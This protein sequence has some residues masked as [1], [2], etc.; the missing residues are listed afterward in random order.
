M[1][2]RAG[3]IGLYDV[4]MIKWRYDRAPLTRTMAG[5]T[6]ISGTRMLRSFFRD[7]MAA[8]TD[9]VGLQ[10]FVVI[11]RQSYRHPNAG[12]MT[13]LARVAGLRVIG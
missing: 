13:Q 11:K 10:G 8:C 4:V 2:T 1:T 9:T 7:R 6:H 3:A 12:V 5:F